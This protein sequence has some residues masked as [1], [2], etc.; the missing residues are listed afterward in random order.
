MTVALWT[1]GVLLALMA[2]AIVARPVR[3][4]EPTVHKPTVGSISGH[5]LM[6]YDAKHRHDRS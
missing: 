1:V 2:V 3:R 5:W 6:E 4:R